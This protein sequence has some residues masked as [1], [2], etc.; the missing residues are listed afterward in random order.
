MTE[1]YNNITGR[2]VAYEMRKK[3]NTTHIIAI[4]NKRLVW[5]LIVDNRLM[6]TSEINEF[7]I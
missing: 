1:I 4:Q 7:M 2:Y 3:F 6:K 5:E